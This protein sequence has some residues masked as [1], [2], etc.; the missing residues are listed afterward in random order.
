MNEILIFLIGLGL[1]LSICL[2][3]VG[4]LQSPLQK[5]LIDLC[6]TEERASFWTAFSTVIL[7][8]MPVVFAMH[9]YPSVNEGIFFQITTQVRWALIGLVGSVVMLGMVIGT[10]IPKE[11]G[12]KLA[13][14]L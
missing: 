13:R 9:S 12:I 3:I 4:S 14:G 2:I 8:L 10:F 6:G 7:I 1:T 5:I 11:R